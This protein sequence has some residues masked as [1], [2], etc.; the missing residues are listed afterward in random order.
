[1]EVCTDT[2]AL[3]R[4]SLVASSNSKVQDVFL[5]PQARYIGK[6]WRESVVVALSFLSNEKSKNEIA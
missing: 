6:H 5:M 2:Y 1:M 3:L 4:Y